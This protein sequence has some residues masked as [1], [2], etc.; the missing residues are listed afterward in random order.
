MFGALA[1][2]VEAGAQDR[3]GF[4][5]PKP[6][7]YGR[8][9]APSEEAPPP[10]PV[11]E[12]DV[13]ANERLVELL[14]D[15]TGEVDLS[16][17]LDEIF[18]DVVAELAQFNPRTIG[19][20]AIRQ[21]VVG[22]NLHPDLAN[23]LK[24]RLTTQLRAGAQVEVLRCLA[25]EATRTQVVDDQLVITHGIVNAT[26]LR[27]VGRELGARTFL[28][29]RLGIDTERMVIELDFELFRAEDAEVIW[30]D[31]FRADETTPMLL[32]ASE[33]AQT[34]EERLDD[35][36]A[37]L[38]GRPFF[39]WAAH[40]GVMLIPYNDPTVG[41]IFAATVGLRLFERFG[42]DRRVIFGLD[43]MGVLNFE[44]LAGGLVSAGAWWVP[45]QPDLVNPELRVGGKAGALIV[46]NTGNT[47]V[48]QLGAEL[49]LRYR[50]GL[51]AYA[52]YTSAA[53][54]TPNNGGASAKLGDGL[55][56]SVGLSFNW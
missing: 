53:D 1:L 10:N 4:E 48:F 5:A 12:R 15:T 6:S 20:L 55:G 41:D 46:G 21:V 9:P 32:R 30:A 26:Q 37:L 56:T 44:L 3:P 42:T 50:F 11:R 51:Y 43:M 34:R 14:Q 35:L 36:R 7:Q 33:A 27:E 19:P 47:T 17:L 31:S 25:C 38:E 39:G 23:Q 8:T 49:L 45:I 29:V 54:F 2:S 24:H 28:D 16:E 22:S 18:A 40:A 13:T 52:T